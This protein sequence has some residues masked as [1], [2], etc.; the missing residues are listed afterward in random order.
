MRCFFFWITLLTCS[1]QVFRFYQNALLIL[2]LVYAI[3]IDACQVSISLSDFLVDHHWILN[4]QSCQVFFF[5]LY[6]LDVH[7]DVWFFL[8]CRCS[9]QYQTILLYCQV[10]ILCMPQ[11]NFGRHIVIAQSVRPSIPLRV[12]C[13]FLI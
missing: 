11:R 3:I 4:S 10:R 13:I 7:C 6:P 8:W 12:R 2:S 9:I 5:T 1:C